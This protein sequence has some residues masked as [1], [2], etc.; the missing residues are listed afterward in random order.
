MVVEKL[1]WRNAPKQSINPA[2]VKLSFGDLSLSGNIK[3]EKSEKEELTFSWDTTGLDL[4]FDRDQ[5][6]LLAYDMD[7]RM[8]FS[9]NTGQFRSNGSDLLQIKANKKSTIISM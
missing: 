3:F 8:A 5:V 4:K 1:L 2:Q 7:H 9:T 6:M